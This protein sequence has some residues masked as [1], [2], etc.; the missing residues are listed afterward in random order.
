MATKPNIVLVHGA[1]GWLTLASCHSTSSSS[2]VSSGGGSEPLD[3]A[4]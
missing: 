2:G 3:V 1:W 4:R